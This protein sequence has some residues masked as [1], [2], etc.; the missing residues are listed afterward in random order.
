MKL[1][2]EQARHGTQ[3]REFN[4]LGKTGSKGWC[5]GFTLIE[6]LV[7]IAIIAILAALLLPALASAKEKARRTRCLSNLRQVHIAMN[8]YAMDN[9]DVLLPAWQQG[10]AFVQLVLSPANAQV[11]ASVGLANTTN[12]ANVW[13]C[14]NRPGL[15][16]V[17]PYNQYALGYQYLGGVTNWING[18][19]GQSYPASSPVKFATSKPTWVLAAEAN[20]K[21]TD[22]GWGADNPTGPKLPHPKPGANVPKGG[23]QV[24]VDGSAQWVRFE[25]MSFVT[26]WGPTRLGCFFQQDL[27]AL[28]PFR[29][30]IAATP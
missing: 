28:E 19:L 13:A 20:V 9:N 10:D 2:P 23:N 15:P 1:K 21:Y 5:G 14:P 6:L 30:A 26:G 12:T 3:G 29:K 4:R 8:L 16:W 18:V 24:Q 27:G 7:V 17:N 25:N 11:A 22:Q